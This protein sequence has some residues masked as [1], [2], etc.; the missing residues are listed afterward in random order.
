MEYLMGNLR[1]LQS[2]CD[3][4]CPY[5]PFLVVITAPRRPSQ[6][7]QTLLGYICPSHLH[8]HSPW[9]KEACFVDVFFVWFK[10]FTLLDKP[11]KRLRAV[12]DYAECPHLSPEF[13]SAFVRGHG[14]RGKYKVLANL[15]W[16]VWL[17]QPIWL[18]LCRGGE[19][20]REYRVWR[21]KMK[22]IYNFWTK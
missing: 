10:I 7:H 11:T 2:I 5:F 14:S 12:E 15:I 16:Q 6:S 22:C 19:C 18:G 4:M 3:K 21:A 20:N 17:G 13:S 1:D 9:G 8:D